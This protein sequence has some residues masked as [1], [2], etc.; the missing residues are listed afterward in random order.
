MNAVEAPLRLEPLRRLV[1]KGE[2]EEE[3]EG[4]GEGG[5]DNRQKIIVQ[6]NLSII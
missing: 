3:G 1:T 5:E 6:W 4:E 2:E